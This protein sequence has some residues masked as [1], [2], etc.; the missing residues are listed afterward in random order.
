VLLQL[1]E[2]I[3]GLHLLQSHDLLD[4]RFETR[5]AAQVVQEWIYFDDK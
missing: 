2:E 1:G 5:I 4:E 3:L